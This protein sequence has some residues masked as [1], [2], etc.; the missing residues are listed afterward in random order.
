M[1]L[2]QVRYENIYLAIKELHTVKVYPITELC[3]IAGIQRSF[4]LQMA[5]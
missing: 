1:V 2:S 5:Q 4:V 3:D